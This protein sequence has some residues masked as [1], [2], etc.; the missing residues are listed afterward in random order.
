MKNLASRGLTTP[1]IAKLAK[2]VIGGSNQRRIRAE[3]KRQ[4]ALRIQETNRELN[5]VRWKFKE[6]SRGVRG[7]LSS[8]AFH[9]Y[10]FIKAEVME[11]T[12]VRES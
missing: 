1:E 4:L 11:S 12:W 5:R 6:T 3:Q 8:Q 10:K 9:N 2:R 7:T